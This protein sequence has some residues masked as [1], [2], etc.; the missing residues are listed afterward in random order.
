MN[1]SFKKIICPVDFSEPSER[2]LSQAVM[3][4][5]QADAELLLITVVLPVPIAAYSEGSLFTEINNLQGQLPELAQKQLAGLR[6]KFCAPISERTSLHVAVGS[7]FVE[8]VRYAREQEADLIV[9][10][11]HGRTG[12]EHLMIGSVAERV[13]RKAPCSVLVVRDTKRR[14]VMP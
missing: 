2:A 14:F 4:A 11:S 7:P 6:D 1:D 5:E 10:G 13:V 3:M 12:I 9:M 8:I